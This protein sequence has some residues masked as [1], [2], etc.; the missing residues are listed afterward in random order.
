M[1]GVNI[2]KHF[3]FVPKIVCSKEKRWEISMYWGDL[4]SAAD[5]LELCFSQFIMETWEYEDFIEIWK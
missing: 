1:E 4:L 2:M 3:F 5:S